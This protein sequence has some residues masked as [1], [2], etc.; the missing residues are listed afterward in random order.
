MNTPIDACKI[1]FD[2][3]KDL[4]LPI[5]LFSAPQD[6]YDK[7]TI[8]FLPGSENQI[9]NEIFVNV[10]IMVN[11]IGGFV[12]SSKLNDYQK[13]VQSALK[14]FSGDQSRVTFAYFRFEDAP[15][16]FSSWN[17]SN[18]AYLNNRISLIFNSN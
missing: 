6:P 10:N 8:N 3:L 17:D 14:S 2:L 15:T 4:G 1:V 11:K 5:Y 16:L 13:L 9:T 18:F 7:I 12:D